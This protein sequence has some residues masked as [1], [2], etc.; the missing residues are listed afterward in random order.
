[1]PTH[2]KKDFIIITM[3]TRRAFGVASVTGI[4][5]ACVYAVRDAPRSDP[6]GPLAVISFFLGTLVCVY[7]NG[8]TPRLSPRAIRRHSLLSDA[9]CG[10]VPSRGRLLS[11]R[12]SCFAIFSAGLAA[13][14]VATH[15]FPW[16]AVTSAVLL[17]MAAALVAHHLE[18]AQRVFYVATCGVPAVAWTA[19]AV[20][21]LRRANN[22][23][24]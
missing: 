22:N 12:A 21:A 15:T 19:A 24:F 20:A 14:H 9:A 4:G 7:L 1:M 23:V 5:A 3:C 11:L 16:P 17:L 18:G 8:T 10:C 2:T 13:L 6:V